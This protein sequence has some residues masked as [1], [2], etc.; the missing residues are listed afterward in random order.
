MRFTFSTI[1]EWSL[2]LLISLF[3]LLPGLTGVLCLY[4]LLIV[5]WGLAIK[6][7]KIT[8]NNCLISVALFLPFYVLYAFNADLSAEAS[9]AVEKKLSFLLFPLVFSAKPR[10]Y[11]SQRK[12]EKGFLIALFLMLIACYIGAFFNYEEHNYESVYLF[13]SHF[14]GLF[15]HPTYVS[16]FCALGIYIL[17]KRWAHPSTMKEHLL[18]A[19]GILFLIY[20]HFHLESLSGLLFAFLL[21]AVLLG[22][23]V[24]KKKGLRFLI[25]VFSIG[26]LSLY[27]LIAMVPSLKSNLLDSASFVSNYVKDPYAYTH[28]P[29]G[30]IRGNDARLILWTASSEI[31]SQHPNGVGVGNLPKALESKLLQYGQVNLAKEQ[32]NPHNQYLHTAIETGW[33]GMTFLLLIIGSMLWFGFKNKEGIVIVVTCAFAFN[34]LFE[35]M[36]ERQSGI[37]FWLMWTCLFIG[38]HQSFKP[39]NHD[40]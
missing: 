3:M 38:I 30:E 17:F 28:L 36:M 23:W 26:L 29:R 25:A 20:T 18:S 13:S 15:H 24:F 19:L 33:L 4:F 10:F 16:A 11:V 5:I 9:F 21:M 14:S 22:N 12:I 34:A 8:R 1:Y 35:S 31:L 7:L 6:Q 2:I 37:V 39:V 27:S 32:L 40:A